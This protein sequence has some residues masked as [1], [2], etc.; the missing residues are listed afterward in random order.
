VTADLER[1]HFN[2]MLSSLME[3]SNYLSKIKESGVVSSSLWGKAIGYFLLLLA[4]TAPHL[5]EELWNRTG[6]PYSIHNQ[7]WPEFDEELAKEKEITLVIQVNGK[8]RDKVLV[9]ASI[10]E[11]EAKELALGRERVKAYIDD[12]KLIRVI[13]VPKRVVNIVVAS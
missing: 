13:Y 10:S 2:T 7:P 3:F 11:V 4:P 8:L 5:A 9:P 1:F 6:H 12:K